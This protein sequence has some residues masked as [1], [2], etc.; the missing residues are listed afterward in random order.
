MG[1][2]FHFKE[3]EEY[4]QH[5]FL[6]TGVPAVYFVYRQKRFAGEPQ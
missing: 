4:R 2:V 1:C 5:E 3:G 6:Q